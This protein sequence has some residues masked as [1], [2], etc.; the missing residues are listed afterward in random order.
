MVLVVAVIAV[1]L[2]TL[3]GSAGKDV[4]SASVTR[5]QALRLLAAN[6]TTT[7]SAAAP[8]LYALVSTGK[9]SAV[10]P[11]GWRATAQA[12]GA[13]NRAE[14]ADPKHHGSTL[15]IVSEPGQAGSDHG[16]ASSAEQAVKRKG[17]T[18]S[19]YGPVSFPGGRRVWH[20]T[21]TDGGVT[22]ATY[23]FSACDDHSAMVVDVASLSGMFEQ[24]QS[25]LQAAAAG[26]QPLC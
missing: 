6:G 7:V 9:L 1:L 24:E 21:Y 14:F 25:K 16:R 18:V 2:V 10:V 5:E 3:G 8:G 20:L 23:F 17:L 13:T 15:T 12:A 4:K 26:A 11:A 22:H 19:S